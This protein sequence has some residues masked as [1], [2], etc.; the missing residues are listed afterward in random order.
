MYNSEL[1]VAEALQLYYQ[2][3]KLPSD[4]GKSSRWVRI[5]I[6]PV[7]FFFPNSSSRL[8]AVD[9]HDMHHIVL[10]RSTTYLD[11]GL[12]AAW[13]LGQGCG[14]Y[15]VAWVLQFQALLWGLILSPKQTFEFFMLGKKSQNLYYSK[16]ISQ[17]FNQSVGELRS[18]I[19][20]EENDTP[21]GRHDYLRFTLYC[22]IGV[23]MVV[24]LLPLYLFPLT[25]VSF[26]LFMNRF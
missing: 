19:L 8:L 20:P 9:R 26:I 16:D 15:T 11:E 13:E 10:N 2:E 21:P 7:P 1:S 25:V 24:L 14:V 17:Y 18:Q 6:G 4:G 12:V 23:M 5:Q 3:N 22:A